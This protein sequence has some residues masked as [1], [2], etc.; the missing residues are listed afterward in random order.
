MYDIFHNLIHKV[1]LSAIQIGFIQV[2]RKCFFS[3]VHIQ[4][5]DLTDEFSKRL[6]PIFCFIFIFR[7][8][9]TPQNFFQCFNIILSHWLIL[10]QFR[11]DKIILVL[12]D[13]IF[14]L[15]LIVLQI[16]VLQFRLFPF[17]GQNIILEIRVITYFLFSKILHQITKTFPNMFKF[18]DSGTIQI[19]RMENLINQLCLHHNFWYVCYRRNRTHFFQQITPSFSIFFSD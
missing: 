4:T 8:Q 3:S 18:I 7:S 10:F 13:I 6:V 11:D 9:I 19:I 17:N 15:C 2:F 12:A 14:C 5:H 1:N 16:I